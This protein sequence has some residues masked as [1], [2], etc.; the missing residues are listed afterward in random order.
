MPIRSTPHPASDAPKLRGNTRKRGF[1]VAVVDENGKT[2]ATVGVTAEGVRDAL[3]KAYEKVSG[4]QS[5]A[6]EEL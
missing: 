4:W 3:K 6:P 1:T 5:A 2:Q